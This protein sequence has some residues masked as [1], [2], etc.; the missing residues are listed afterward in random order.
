[1]EGVTDIGDELT[2][3]IG[4]CEIVIY[5]TVGTFTSLTTQGDDGEVGLLSLYID[6]RTTDGHL[7]QYS[8]TPEPATTG[9]SC[10][11]E[12]RLVVLIALIEVGEL[13]V[14]LQSGLCEALHHVDGIG[15]V[16]VAGTGT[17]SNEVIG[18]NAKDRDGLRIVH[19]Q[20]L[21]IV[22]QQH[23]T[24]GS[25][26]A[27]HVGM[28]FQV[29]LVSVFIGTESRCLRKILQDALHADVEV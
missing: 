9:R 17:A 24:L 5:L 28:G 6:D 1:M 4:K 22:L 13:G 16:H 7:R 29:G 23:H 2:L 21:T 14:H 19:R 15:F 25:A 20:R 26:T 3:H 18:G 11:C 10:S 27:R 8:F 12:A